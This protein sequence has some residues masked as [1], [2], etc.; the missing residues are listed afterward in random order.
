MILYFYSFAL[1]PITNESQIAVGNARADLC[2]VQCLTHAVKDDN[3]EKEREEEEKEDEDE[4]EDDD[5]FR[6]EWRLMTP[7]LFVP[8]W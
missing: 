5:Y 7:E 2:E 4:E 3:E 8:R 1:H 6:E